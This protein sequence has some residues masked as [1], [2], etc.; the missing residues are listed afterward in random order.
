MSCKVQQKNHLNITGGSG[1]RWPGGGEGRLEGSDA[2]FSKNHSSGSVTSPTRDPGNSATAGTSCRILTT[3][4]KN[5]ST[6]SVPCPT[7]G[8]GNSAAAGD[9]W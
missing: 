4:S 5:H 7:R 2:I 3:F 1:P 8:P 6:G 9:V